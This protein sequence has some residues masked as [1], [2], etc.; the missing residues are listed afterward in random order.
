MSPPKGKPP[1]ADSVPT[2]RRPPALSEALDSPIPI[3]GLGLSVFAAPLKGTAPN[4]SIALTL[5]VEG[6]GLTFAEQERPVRGRRRGQRARG[7]QGRQ[8]QGRRT[9][10]RAAQAASRRPTRRVAR[11]G[12]RISRR[13]ELPPGRYQLRVGVR[14]GGSGATG[15]VLYDLD[16]PDFS[17][18]P[19]SMSGLL[20]TL[21][22]RDSDAV[23]EPRSGVQGGAAG[24]A[25]PRSAT[26]R[27]TTRWRSSP[28]S[29]TTRLKVAHRVVHQGDGDCRRRQ[30]GAHRGGRAEERGAA[31]RQGR[32]RATRPRSRPRRWRPA[33]TSCASRRT[34]LLTDGGKAM[35]ELE[36]RI[37]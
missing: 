29:T 21:G 24:A 14:D 2:R 37:R 22:V 13:L 17:K 10:C 23:R 4:A 34:T 25:R 35:R 1:A 9:R 5:E 28:R 6:R 27:A 16:V 32:L 15:S 26:S 36:F 30:G 11:H 8:D 19:L 7:G 33:A 18:E 31:G 12:V 3:S 20:L